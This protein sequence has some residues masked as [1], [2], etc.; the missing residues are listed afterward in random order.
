ML[1]SVARHNLA[2]R[3]EIL[4]D[5][6]DEL[7]RQLLAE[8]SI[9]A[10]PSLAEGL[11]L[12]LQEAI[13]NKAACVGSRIGGIPDLILHEQTGLLVPPADSTA[14]AIG[15]TRLMADPS[16]RVR[17]GNAGRAHVLANGMTRNGM[18]ERHNSLYL[19]AK[20]CSNR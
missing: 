3:V 12:S 8:A 4:T 13:Y 20:P 2:E 11:G 15:L 1:D 17:L 14:L 16:L 6:S 5:V 19:L 9:F 18:I 7:A 10:M